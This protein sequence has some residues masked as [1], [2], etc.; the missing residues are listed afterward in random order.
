MDNLSEN[1]T[2]T[3]NNDIII[4]EGA[5][6][7]GKSSISQL[8]HLKIRYSLFLKLAPSPLY[9]EKNNGEYEKNIYYSAFDFIKN[10]TQNTI[11]LDR[12]FYSEYIY[13]EM[14]KSYKIGYLKDLT[15]KLSNLNRRIFF[16]LLTSD[17]ETIVSRVN[18][19]LV[20]TNKDYI[21]G[22]ESKTI[23]DEYVK[24]QILFV[25]KFNEIEGENFY[26]KIINN[27]LSINSVTDSIMQFINGK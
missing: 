4:F 24:S 22:Q 19:R 9:F 27:N 20:D 14:Y 17:F 18:N 15:R 23:A 25:E 12:F 8:L 7:T 6:C 1:M 10:T 3:V 21:Y 16:I 26:K 11:I 13:S 2:R 5:N